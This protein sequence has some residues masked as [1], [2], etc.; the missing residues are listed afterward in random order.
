MSKHNLKCLNSLI[1]SRVFVLKSWLH[2]IYF[3]KIFFKFSS[4][5]KTMTEI[6]NVN[7]W[8][9]SESVSGPGSELI[10]TKALV[11]ELP[12]L[13][14]KFDIR[15]IFDAPCGDFNWM[16]KV[17]EVSN[18]SYLGG[19]IVQKIVDDNNASFSNIDRKFKKI[20]ITC[21]AF[22]SSDLWLCRH[23]FFHLSFQ[24]IFHSLANFLDAKIPYVLLTNSITNTNHVNRNIATGNWR[25]LN[26]FDEP[27]NFPKQVLWTVNDY[28]PPASPTNLILFNREQLVVPINRLRAKL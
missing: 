7:Y 24:D 3:E 26:L 16:E 19:D 1:K 17:L 18:I 4:T 5:E 28:V 20:D 23:T 6:Y 21:E 10:Q 27:F 25:P 13:F 15:S 11:S 2:K 12:E 22:P 14:K 9:S 8:G